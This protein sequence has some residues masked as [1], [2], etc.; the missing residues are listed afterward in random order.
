MLWSLNAFFFG[1][2][3]NA[4]QYLSVFKVDTER[5]VNFK[6]KTI[7]KISRDASFIS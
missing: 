4:F 7:Y 1:S 5:S 2:R 3:L 6:P